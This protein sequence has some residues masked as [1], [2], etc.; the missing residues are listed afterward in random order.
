MSQ[1]DLSPMSDED[2]AAL[3]GE[4]TENSNN[5]PTVDPSSTET[6]VEK[7]ETTVI[8]KLA[9]GEIP[10]M[11]EEDI[12]A[13]QEFPEE[14]DSKKEKTDKFTKG[15][16]RS[17]Y[18]KM[19][20]ES[21]EWFP[22]TDVEGK[23]VEDLELDDESFQE[24]A[25]KQAQW[26]AD[27]ILQEREEQLGEQYKEFVEFMKNGGKVEDLARFEAE[28]KD[29]DSYD[30]T[31]PEDAEELIKAYKTSKGESEKTIKKYLE[32]LKDQGADELREIAEE[33]KNALLKDIQTEKQELIKEQERQAKYLKE[34]QDNYIK[35]FKEVIFK[36]SLPERE[37]KELEKFY[38]DINHLKPDG[39]KASQFSIKV[40]E[41]QSD[42][43]KFLNNS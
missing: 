37:K 39:S 8:P 12:T 4:S 35:A 1:F 26:K 25:I 10:M 40:Q 6:K 19:L 43:S 15:L 16:D 36:D 23:P 17:Q 30:P 9:Q 34:T 7:T 33:S 27:E 5:K 42:P 38:F 2:I 41:I 11:S 24:L 29:V 21:G 3:T 32:F 31:N 14:S 22:V 28:Q 18:Y 20:V 13:L